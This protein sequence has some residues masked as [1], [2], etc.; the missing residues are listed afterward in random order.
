M[1]IIFNAEKLVL[2]MRRNK[3]AF[4]FQKDYNSCI[5]EHAVILIDSSKS[6]D[7]LKVM[8]KLPASTC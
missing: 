1:L 5:H 8:T 2:D 6:G 3:K 7:A 4:F